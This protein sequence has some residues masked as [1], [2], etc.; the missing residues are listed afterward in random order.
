MINT[1][2]IDDCLDRSAQ[3]HLR[4]TRSPATARPR[5]Y[6][7]LGVTASV[8]GAAGHPGRADDQLYVLLRRSSAVEIA[9]SP[10]A[11]GLWPE[12]AL[13]LHQAPDP[14]AVGADIRLDVG[15]RRTDGGQIDAEQ[16]GASL[17][18]C[19]D[20]PAQVRVVPSPHAASVSNTSS[21][22]IGNDA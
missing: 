14:G 20:R 15:S 21:K 7:N 5:G 11:V 4:L 3:N 12:L 19:R 6:M 22:A 9:A 17:Q 8:R 18:R 1:F 13:Q 2:D 10:S 16:L